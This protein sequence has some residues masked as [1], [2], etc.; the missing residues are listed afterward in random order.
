M[1]EAPDK[2]NPGQKPTVKARIAASILDVVLFS[3]CGTTLILS[4]SPHHSPSDGQIFGSVMAC[5]AGVIMLLDGTLR[6]LF[7]FTILLTSVFLLWENHKN[8][9]QRAARYKAL[10]FD[11]QKR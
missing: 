5:T 4:Q 6:R 7:G 2:K 9:E 10:Y 11:A 8:T 3:I 1:S